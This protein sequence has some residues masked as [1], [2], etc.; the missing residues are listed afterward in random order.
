M[1]LDTRYMSTKTGWRTL[2]SVIFGSPCSK[3]II[4]DLEMRPRLFLSLLRSML[5]C[6]AGGCCVPDGAQNGMCN[7]G[8]LW[9][10]VLAVLNEQSLFQ[11]KWQ[12]ASAKPSHPSLPKCRF[13]QQHFTTS[14]WRRCIPAACVQGAE[15][16]WRHQKEHEVYRFPVHMWHWLGETTEIPIAA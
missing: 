3:Q 7:P 5:Q 4:S 12:P 13:P 6:P 8:A 9:A 10:V 2:T 11:P 14:C 16:V 15:R 1:V